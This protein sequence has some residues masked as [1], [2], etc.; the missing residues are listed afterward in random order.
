MTMQV[1][2]NV[3]SSAGAM[4]EALYHEAIHMLLFIEDLIPSSPTSK[5]ATSFAGYK[6]TA[7]ASAK[8]ATT[9]GDLEAYMSRDWTTRKVASPPNPKKAAKEVLDHIVEE[10]YAFDQERVQFGK[11]PSN[12]TLVDGYLKD[13]FRDMNITFDATS[14]T[15]QGIASGLAAILDDIDRATARRRSP[16]RR[17]NLRPRHLRSRRKSPDP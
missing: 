9:L 17:R 2:S 14:K 7:A 4:A 11:G 5:H 16:H 3:T 13:G 6:S 1:S 15:L 10:K 8:T 12:T